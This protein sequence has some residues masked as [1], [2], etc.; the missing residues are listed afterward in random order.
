VKRR[1]VALPVAALVAGGAT[2]L[3]MAPETEEASP[4]VSEVRPATPARHL[5][6]KRMTGRIVGDPVSLVAAADQR[7]WVLLRTRK[8]G[9][10]LARLDPKG[11]VVT[12]PVR[13]G[14]PLEVIDGTPPQRY[15]AFAARDTVGMV[16]A[17]GKL[18]LL[19][20]VPG[21]AGIAFDREGDLWYA[22]REEGVVRLDPVH[23]V[24]R[25]GRR[26]SS[27]GRRA[28]GDLT[29]GPRGDVWA[30]YQ[31]GG[32]MDL[33]SASPRLRRLPAAPSNAGAPVGG[34]IA[35]DAV[36]GVWTTWA[37]RVVHTPRRGAATVLRFGRSF[38]PGAIVTGP[39]GNVW[40]AARRGPRV[41]RIAPDRRVRLFRLR[42]PAGS[43]ITDLGRVPGRLRV[44]AVR[45]AAVYEVPL[46]DLEP[47]IAGRD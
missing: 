39:D 6:A 47:K 8:G 43:S 9:G 42:V 32:V 4:R 18:Q 34:G 12:H 15:L 29:L 7:V 25:G 22:S 31:G 44:A 33:S 37:D 27:V 14:A 21:V 46:P 19:R 38:R 17:S 40:C 24:P 36:D 1:L 28:I 10:R 3:L 30:R 20:S 41:V 26:R 13:L 35:G 2:G 5:A 23:G 45:P 16:H 11:K